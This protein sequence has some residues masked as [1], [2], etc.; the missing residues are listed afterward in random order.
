[1]IDLVNQS[2]FTEKKMQFI[3][4]ILEEYYYCKKII[5]KHF[6]KN[7]VMS[8]EDEERFESSNICWICDRLFDAG[9]NKVRDHCHITEKYRGSEHWSCNINL[10]LTKKVPIIF[11]NLSG[12]DIDSIIREI[13][14]FDV[15]V[16]V[17]PN[18]L[19]KYMDFTINKNLVFI[20]SIHFMNSRLDALVKNSSDNDFKYLSE[21]FSGGLLKLVK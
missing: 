20:D 13:R 3:K 17:I 2:F 5:K 10:K 7:L 16:N 18:G 14:K 15:I 1:M 8:A 11:H 4:A 6:N 19:K 9:D 21:E 12:Y